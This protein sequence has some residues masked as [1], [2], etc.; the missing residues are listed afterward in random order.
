MKI[1]RTASLEP[2]FTGSCRKSVYWRF[3]F[4]FQRPN[5]KQG[6]LN[7]FRYLLIFQRT[8]STWNKKAKNVTKVVCASFSTPQT[9]STYAGKFAII[10]SIMLWLDFRSAVWRQV[11]AYYFLYIYLDYGLDK[12]RLYMNPWYHLYFLYFV[13][14]FY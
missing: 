10:F 6:M 5:S 13:C 11:H 12:I 1:L 14:V 7:I 2:N 3:N 8:I 9:S 4:N